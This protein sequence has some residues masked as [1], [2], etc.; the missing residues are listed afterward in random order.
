LMWADVGFNRIFSKTKVERPDD[1][2]KVKAWLWTQDG[3]YRTYY[4]TAGV[5]PVPLALP[6]VLPALQTGLV[7]AQTSPPLAALSLQW[8]TKANF[9][10]DVSIG[11]II[12]AVVLTKKSLD[13]L[14]PADRAIVLAV[15]AEAGEAMRKLAR[16]D[17]ERAIEAM[18]KAGLQIVSPD[19]ATRALW[20]ELGKRAAVAG[21]GSVYPKDLY[22]EVVQAVADYRAGA[23]R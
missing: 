22:D 13:A 16:A 2:K 14:S 7:D 12:G 3:V 1:L 15:G 6:D 8:F 10:L 21:A 4:E 17:N 20:D 23:K 5:K 9:M 18:K 19:A 11:A